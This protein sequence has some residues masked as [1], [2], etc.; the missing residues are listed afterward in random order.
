VIALGNDDRLDGHVALRE[1]H[2]QVAGEGGR[3]FKVVYVVMGD[4]AV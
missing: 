2:E 4:E 1:V 3:I